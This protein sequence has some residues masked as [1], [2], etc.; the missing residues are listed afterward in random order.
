VY[1]FVLPCP[2][3]AEHRDGNAD[4]GN[5]SGVQPNLGTRDDPVVLV[6]D[7]FQIFVDVDAKDATGQ[8]GADE[9]AHECESGLAGVEAVHLGKDEREGLEPDIEKSWG[10]V[11]GASIGSTHRI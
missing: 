2:A 4:G 6:E 5:R 1:R 11:E 9:D 3:E 8:P 10:L 7:R